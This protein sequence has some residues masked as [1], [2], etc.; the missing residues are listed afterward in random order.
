MKTLYSQ[1]NPQEGRSEGKR[2]V[3]RGD[4]T[5][6]KPKSRLFLFLKNIYVTLT[7]FGGDVALSWVSLM[8]GNGSGR[9]RCVGSGGRGGVAERGG[10][11][12]LLAF[13]CRTNRI[14]HAT[15]PKSSEMGSVSS[16]SRKRI[17]RKKEKSYEFRTRRPRT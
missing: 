17:E 2:H 3:F 10:G 13:Q 12:R 8:G 5:G 9:A 14:P 16:K 15:T 4:T 1:D 7:S 11:P 6:A